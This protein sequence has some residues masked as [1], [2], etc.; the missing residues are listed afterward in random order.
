[1]WSPPLAAQNGNRYGSSGQFADP[2]GGPSPRWTLTWDMTVDPDPFINAV[3]GLT[4]NT[5][6]Y[7]TYT[8][9]AQLLIAPAITPSSLIGGSMGGSL[10]DANYDGLGGLAT[11]AAS[12]LYAGMIDGAQALPIY[13]HSSSW[14][15]IFAG[16]T[17]TI[18]SINSG[19]P[20]PTIPGPAVLNSIGIEHRFTLSPGDSASF[21]SFFVAEVP[22]PA[23][24]SLLALG[25]LALLRRR[26]R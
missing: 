1:M 17:I 21:T 5:N 9:S 11:V 3:F 25:G 18:P 4:N 22:E 8:L 14:S 24:L 6:A 13:P 15:F 26:S 10:T 16:E 2:E 7:Q 19:L 23:S 12:P 20:G